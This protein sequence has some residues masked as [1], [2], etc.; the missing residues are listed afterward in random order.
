MKYKR[1]RQNILIMLQDRNM[2]TLEIYDRL[3]TLNPRL[4]PTM[5]QLANILSKNKDVFP[6]HHHTDLGDSN[7]AYSLSGHPYKVTVWGLRR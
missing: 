4:T 1:A 3:K 6:V 7:I 2:N 5:N